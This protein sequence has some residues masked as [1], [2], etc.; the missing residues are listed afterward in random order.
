M[1]VGLVQ[2]I[3]KELHI[4]APTVD[5]L[6]VFHCE[7]HHQRLALVAERLKSGRQGVKAG[8]LAGLQP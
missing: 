7:L 1:H 2:T 8:I 5:V 6:L 4:A 3:W